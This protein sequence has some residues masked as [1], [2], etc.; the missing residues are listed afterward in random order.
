MPFKNRTDTVLAFHRCRL[1]RKTERT[2]LADGRFELEDF[3]WSLGVSTL[4][5]RDH[6][7]AKVFTVTNTQSGVPQNLLRSPGF[8]IPRPGPSPYAATIPSKSPT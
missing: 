8:T 5:T 6:D 4:E 7:H 3:D 2:V 1:G